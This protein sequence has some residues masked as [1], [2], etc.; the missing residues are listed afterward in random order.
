MSDGVGKNSHKHLFSHLVSDVSLGLLMQFH[1]II[2]L[3]SSEWWRPGPV[4][5]LFSFDLASSCILC[6]LSLSTSVEAGT[7]INNPALCCHTLSSMCVCCVCL[8]V[9]VMS[10]MVFAV[11]TGHARLYHQVTC[12]CSCEHAHGLMQFRIEKPLGETKR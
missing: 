6:S 10:K 11:Q 2:G 5:C 7:S 9:C 12:V 3:Y 4:S 8:C 1:D